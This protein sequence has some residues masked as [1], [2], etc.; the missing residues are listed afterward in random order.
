MAAA[1]SLLM[2]DE[3]EKQERK[4]GIQVRAAECIPQLSVSTISLLNTQSHPM[5]E[6]VQQVTRRYHAVNTAE[7]KYRLAKRRSCWALVAG[8]WHIA[9]W[10]LL[11]FSWV[12]VFSHLD[13][14]AG[15]SDFWAV[16]AIVMVFV[17]ILNYCCVIP[18]A[19]NHSCIE[20]CLSGPC[21]LLTVK[22]R[23]VIP[24]E[25]T[26]VQARQQQSEAAQAAH[27]FFSLFGRKQL[28]LHSLEEATQQTKLL[29]IKQTRAFQ[30]IS[31]SQSSDVR[32][33]LATV[34][35]DVVHQEYE[36]HQQQAQITK[37]EIQIA[38]QQVETLHRWPW[39][40]EAD[41]VVV[42]NVEIV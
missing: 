37:Q 7:N 26:L 25:T 11:I 8:V 27:Q 42:G 28:L 10:I 16:T 3:N 23:A 12:W 36:K 21:I 41:L 33:H 20:E 22:Q 34:L 6:A 19:S 39:S 29:E 31:N 24:A 9:S 40:R 2:V 5:P 13:D 18:F 1:E 32:E 4:A 14:S 38:I 15:P 17:T 35:G 30:A